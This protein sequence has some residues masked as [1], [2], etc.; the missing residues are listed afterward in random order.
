M[1]FNVEKCVCVH[2]GNKN[3][4]LIHNIGGVKLKSVAKEKN[5]R[6]IIAENFKFSEQC[7]TAAKKAN[8][9]LGIIKRKV[10]TSKKQN[11]TVCSMILIHSSLTTTINLDEEIYVRHCRIQSLRLKS[12]LICK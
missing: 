9:V 6:V 5:L 7:A 2:I 4:N 1:K 8:Q 3:K 10:K 12:L 11:E